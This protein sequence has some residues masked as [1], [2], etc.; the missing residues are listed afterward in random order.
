MLG[1]ITELEGENRMDAMPGYMDVAETIRRRIA[2][3]MYPIG[4]RLPAERELAESLGTSR[5]SLRE[6]LQI[7]ANQKM[8]QSHPGGSRYVMRNSPIDESDDHL[9][10]QME[11]AAVSDL[12][13]ARETLDDVLLTLA[14]QRA[15]EEDMLEIDKAYERMKEEKE[16]SPVLLGAGDL[17]HLA[18]AK[19]AHNV[20]FISVYSANLEIFSRIRAATL[21]IPGRKKEMI[22]EHIDIYRA[23][24]DRDELAAR[25]AARIHLRNIRR[26]YDSI[27]DKSLN[28]LR[29]N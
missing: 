11:R 17:F 13:E 12:L 20:V 15:T 22:H 6:A 8:I 19:A 3:G 29:G 4:S 16:I 27:R 9:Y 28:D 7:L 1:Q 14:C 25:L 5:G 26:R 10:V 2:S 24:K 21:Q 18:V 23:V